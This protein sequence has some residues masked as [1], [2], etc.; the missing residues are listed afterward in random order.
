MD[1]HP[2]HLHG[3]AFEDHRDG[4]RSDRRSRRSGR[5]RRCSSPSG[6]TRTIEF[7]ADDPGDWAM[8]CHMTH[9]VMNQMGHGLPNMVGVEPGKLDKQVRAFLPGYM[10]MGQDGMAE[11]GE[12]GMTVPPN[13]VPMVGSP[14]PHDYITMGG[15]FTNLKVRKD[16]GDLRPEDGKDFAYGGWYE[17]PPGT[18]AMRAS[19]EDLKRDLGSIP[20]A[21]PMEKPVHNMHHG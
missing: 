19:E 14:G 3:H 13:S 21:K 9:H 10:T 20:D 12:M 17:N 6:S 16:L 11:M 7:V 1:H 15:M 5:R 2:I 18:E 8:H 4:R